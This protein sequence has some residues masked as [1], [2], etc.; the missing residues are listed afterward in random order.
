MSR[1]LRRPPPPDDQIVVRFVPL[2]IAEEGEAKSEAELRAERAVHAM[3][4]LADPM[5]VLA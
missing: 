5:P 1:A 4:R 3:L 2:I